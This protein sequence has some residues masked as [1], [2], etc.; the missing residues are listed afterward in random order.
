[1]SSSPESIFQA[2][3]TRDRDEVRILMS[4]V[5][6][7]VWSSLTRGGPRLQGIRLEASHEANNRLLLTPGG[8]QAPL[9]HVESLALLFGPR[10]PSKLLE[11]LPES[12]REALRDPL[13]WPVFALG[14]DAI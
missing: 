6:E 14:F 4:P 12:E 13:P 9:T 3:I 7:Q 5:Q 10:L 11:A 1:M 2:P 8:Q